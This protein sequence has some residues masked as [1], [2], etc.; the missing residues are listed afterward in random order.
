[1][2]RS[3]LPQSKDSN[4]FTPSSPSQNLKMFFLLFRLCFVWIRV[5]ACAS[6]FRVRA[7]AHV[8]SKRGAPRL[9][10]PLAYR[11]SKCRAG[12]EVRSLP[13]PARRPAT[14][15]HARTWLAALPCG[16]RF[17]QSERTLPLALTLRQVRRRRIAGKS[18]D[19]PPRAPAGYPARVWATR[20]GPQS[21][22]P[23]RSS[24]ERAFSWPSGPGPDGAGSCNVSRFL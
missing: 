1:M 11:F 9:S 16:Q 13:V 5:G 19:L 15:S 6:P 24:P 2:V 17:A 20:A 18:A 7:C 12:N 23:A 3:G 10:L 21:G 14:N 22:G 8:A 4:F